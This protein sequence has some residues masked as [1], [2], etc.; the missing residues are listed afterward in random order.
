V[1][2]LALSNKLSKIKFLSVFGQALSI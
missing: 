1:P 2:K